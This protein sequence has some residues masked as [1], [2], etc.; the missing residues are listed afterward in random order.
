[1]PNTVR[2]PDPRSL[3]SRYGLGRTYS[4]SPGELNPV[5]NKKFSV[6][7]IS[8]TTVKKL[9]ANIYP[10]PEGM[11]IETHPPNAPITIVGY[12]WIGL[13]AEGYYFPN[14]FLVMGYTVL[15]ET[16]PKTIDVV[17]GMDVIDK[18]RNM[19]ELIGRNPNFFEFFNRDLSYL[20]KSDLKARFALS[21]MKKS[22]ES[23]QNCRWLARYRK[24]SP[25]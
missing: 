16:D 24:K 20:R 5:V 2:M 23:L 8:Y 17:F 21:A 6:S 13:C 10:L 15:E 22:E 25:Q 14:P 12:A 18:F 9:G 7:V 3:M 1:M 19:R 11:P 4:S